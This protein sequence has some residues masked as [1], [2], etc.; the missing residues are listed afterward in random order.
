LPASFCSSPLLVQASS[1]LTSTAI[2]A[3]QTFLGAT[4]IQG[5]NP[6]W[7]E[8]LLEEVIQFD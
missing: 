5:G 6:W 1:N 7:L 2:D 4:K 3:L 8:A